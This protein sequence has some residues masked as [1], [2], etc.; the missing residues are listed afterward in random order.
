M[1][2]VGLFIT[3]GSFVRMK[4]AFPYKAYSSGKAAFVLQG[5]PTGIDVTKVSSLGLEKLKILLASEADI[6]INGENIF[7]ISYGQMQDNLHL[8]SSPG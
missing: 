3:S 5:I 4:R 7:L 2:N 1:L 6:R 8:F